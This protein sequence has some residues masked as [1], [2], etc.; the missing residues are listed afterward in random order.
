MSLRGGAALGV[1]LFCL[2][3]VAPA[4][5]QDGVQHLAFSYG[6]LKIAPG[7]NTM[8]RA[9]NQQRPAVD[10][11]IVGFRANLQR[12][13]GSVPRGDVIHL[14]HG[15]WLKDFAPLFAA[16]EEKTH[17]TAPPGYGWRYRTGDAWH[18][19]HMIHNLTPDPDEVFITYEI[20]F[21]P[22]GA[23]PAHGIQTIETAWLDTVGGAYPVFDAK[24]GSGGSDRRFTY[25]DEAEAAPRH[26]W[27][28]PQDG[29]LVRTAGHLHPGGLWTD[30]ELTRD[31]RSTRLFRS[32]AIYHEPAG[33][34]SWD[35]SMTVT[36]PDWRVQLRKGDV[37]SVSGTYDTRKA[38]WY[39]SMAIMP[40]MWVPGGTGADPFT[41]NVD[42]DGRVTHGHLPEND[43]H[44]GG[45]MSGLANPL[46]LLSRPVPGK[47]RVAIQGFVYGQGDLSMTGR[48]GRP[49]QVRKGRGLE[50]VNRDAGRELFH[51]VTACRAPCNRTTGIAYPLADA[52][53]GFDSG[54]LGFGPAGFTAA[55]NRDTWTTPK[56]LKPGRYTYFC[57]VHPFMRGS[58]E[59]KRKR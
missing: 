23:P 7:R 18:M 49:A 20:D 48:R 55:A 22:D 34:V 56:R 32:K 43:V 53:V 41:T 42:V 35:V 39:E 36:P 4:P 38:S 14:H 30:L 2:A 37:L 28:V 5:A 3:V 31:G 6:P 9:I 19:I 15:V 45:R 57:R 46:E 44:G 21:I 58:F 10:G 54:Q 33:A 50:F 52:K 59:V 24:R 25:P 27:T 12:S 51:T 11:W 13:D 26:T 17:I 16:G 8:E 47:P 40:A 29:A 1:L